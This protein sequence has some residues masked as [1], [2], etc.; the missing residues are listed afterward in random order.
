MLRNYFP[1][2][3][4][5]MARPH[6]WGWVF[7]LMELQ[8]HINHCRTQLNQIWKL[9]QDLQDD[10]IPD[11]DPIFDHLEE[12]TWHWAWRLEV[13]AAMDPEYRLDLAGEEIRMN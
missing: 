10:G 12:K 13:L 4:R 2:A 1:V 6:E 9:I 11:Q 7:T 5:C 8:T 3:L